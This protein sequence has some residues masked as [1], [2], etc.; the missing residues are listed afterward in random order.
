MGVRGGWEVVKQKG[1]ESMELGT[2]TGRKTQLDNSCL[3]IGKTE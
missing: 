2:G 3:L 1:K